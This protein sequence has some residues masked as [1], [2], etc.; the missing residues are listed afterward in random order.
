MAYINHL[1]R[2]VH[3]KNMDREEDLYGLEEKILDYDQLE[4]ICD[5]TLLDQVLDF[6]VGK[7][8]VT[9]KKYEFVYIQQ[10]DLRHTYQL[11]E[12]GKIQTDNTNIVLGRY[13]SHF[14]RR[15]KENLE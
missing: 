12:L 10:T 13:D 6:L 3:N 9:G 7:E 11:A 14:L 5:L 8:K 15:L 1:N 4:D 2:Q